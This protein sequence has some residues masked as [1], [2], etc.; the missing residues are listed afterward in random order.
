VKKKVSRQTSR[1]PSLFHLTLLKADISCA[2]QPD[3]S[4]A[5]DTLRWNRL[6]S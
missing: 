6:A 5:S 1:C 3:I 4:C 2:T